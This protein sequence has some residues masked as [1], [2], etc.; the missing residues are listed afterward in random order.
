MTINQYTS[1]DVVRVTATFTDLAGTE[2]DPST[3]TVLYE[4]P[5]GNVT[6]KVYGVDGEVVKSATGIYYID[7]TTDEGGV[8]KYRFEG[9]GTVPQAHQSFF[10]VIAASVVSA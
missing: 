7:I 3:V 9:T 8:W 1:G 6:S 4:D 10:E 2:T 5:S